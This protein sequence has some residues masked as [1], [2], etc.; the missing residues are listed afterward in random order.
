MAAFGMMGAD[1]YTFA[2]VNTKLACNDGL[3]VAYTDRLSRTSFDAVDA[4]IA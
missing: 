4:A 2:A 3:A 1:A